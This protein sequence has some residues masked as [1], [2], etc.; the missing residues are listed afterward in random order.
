M[1][2]KTKILLMAVLLCISLLSWAY[3][4]DPKAGEE[5][6]W[7]VISNGG[8][9]GSSTNYGLKGTV[10]QTATGGGSSSSYGMSHG[11]WQDFGGSSG[12]CQGKCGDANGD[13]PVNVSD[14]VWIINYVFVGGDP[15]LPV[16]ACGDAN[17]DTSVNVSDAVWIINYVFVGGDAPGDCSPGGPN[18]GGNDCCVFTP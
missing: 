10:S 13:G 8:T 3:A 2:M 4:D 18:W 14:A 6:N 17:T 11:F 15:P 1:N 12:P 9:D 16:L 7:Q 5:I